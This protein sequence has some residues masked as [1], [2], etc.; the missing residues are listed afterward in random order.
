MRYHNG[1]LTTP[2]C[3]SGVTWFVFKTPLK[4]KQS[5]VN[6]FAA[7]HPVNARPV[8]TFS[9]KFF[10]NTFDFAPKQKPAGEQ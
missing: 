5:E 4:V 2:D 6:A 10:A 7:H 9:G 1:S 8:Q 3:R